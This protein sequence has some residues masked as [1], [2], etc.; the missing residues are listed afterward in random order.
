V[1]FLNGHAGYIGLLELLVGGAIIDVLQVEIKVVRIVH[2]RGDL[3]LSNWQ[4]RGQG[5]HAGPLA[6]AEVIVTEQ[7]HLVT[8]QIPRTSAHGLLAIPEFQH[9]LPYPPGQIKGSAIAVPGI[10]VQLD[11]HQL[12]HAMKCSMGQEHQLIGVNAASKWK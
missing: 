10:L 3:I 4:P 5:Q 8:S 1:N 11:G 7:T 9:K 6:I 2:R 12:L